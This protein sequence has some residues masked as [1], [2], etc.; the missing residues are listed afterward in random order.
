MW[1]SALLH[2]QRGLWLGLVTLFA[3]CA[4][5]TMPHA[6]A[7][8]S[9][10][11]PPKVAEASG[12]GEEALKGFRIPEGWK[13]ELYAAE[14]DVANPVALFIDNQ[15]QVYVCESFRQSRG[16][17]D[18]RSHDQAWT[19]ADIAARTVEDRIAY[20]RRLLPDAGASYE[21]EIDRIRRLVDRD[22]NGKADSSEV[23]VS[24]FH[25]I[26]EG[27]GAG[28]LVH[29]DSIFYTCIPKLWEFRDADRDG[30]V[31]SQRVI[32]D[33]F[34]VRVALRGH[35]MHGLVMGPDG[36]LYFSIGDRGYHVQTEGKLLADPASG[37]VFRC[38]LDGSHF[39]VF[40]TGLRNPQELAFDDYGR[41]FTGDN[42]SDSGDK[43]RWVYVVQ[44]GDTGWRMHYQYHPT[45]GPF[46][47]EH[48][49]EPFSAQTPAYIIPPVANV[50]DGPS[51]LTFYPGT[52]LSDRFLDTFLL[53]DFRGQAS[54]SGIRAL[55]VEEKGAFFTLSQ[56]EEL[57]WQVLA[58]DIDFGPDGSL[59]FSD[60]V[61]GWEGEGKGR[62]YRL[63]D[64]PN[65]KLGEITRRLLSSQLSKL[66]KANLVEL[67]HFPDRRVRYEAQWALAAQEEVDL[68]YQAA[69]AE[70]P[71][72]RHRLHGVW[73]LGQIARSSSPKAKP[74]ADRLMQLLDCPSDR[75]AALA[76]TMLAEA[77]HSAAEEKIVT[78]VQSP[79]VHVR[80]AAS[81][82]LGTLALPTG[83][84]AACQL[85]QTNQDADPIV[86]HAGIMALAGQ[87]NLDEV[88]GL[89]DHPIASVRR[90]AVVALRKRN[91]PRIA[92]F[93]DDIDSKVAAE[94]ARAIY[95]VLTLE[96][97]LPRLAA[98]LERAGAELEWS[99]RALHA[100]FRLG[101]K[102]NAEAVAQYVGGS[103]HSEE[104]RLEGLD[105]LKSWDAPGELDRL[106]SDYRPIANR[107]S[108]FAKEALRAQ[109]ALIAA[110]S[111]EV[112]TKGFEVAANLG[113]SE[114][115]PLLLSVLAD[116]NAPGHMRASAL[117][118]LSLIDPL[119]ATQQAEK[120]ATDRSS[121][122]KIAALQWL[123]NVAPEKTLEPIQQ[124]SQSTISM[125][126]QAAW[127]L[128]GALPEGLGLQWLRQGAKRYLEK[129]LPPDVRLNVFEA[130]QKR[131]P[132]QAGSE[133][134]AM[135]QNQNLAQ[136]ENR[137]GGYEDC[138]EGG[139][140]LVGKE[141][142]LQ[143]SQLSCVRC[144]RVGEKGGEVGPILSEIG[145][146]K[147][148]K[149]LLEAIVNPNAQI[150]EGFESTVVALEDG[151]V[152]TGLLKGETDTHLQLL[153]ADGSQVSIEKAAVAGRRKGLSSMPADLVKQL[154][155][156]ELRDL[157]AYLRALDGK[158]PAL[159]PKAAGH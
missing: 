16:V 159:L 95:D 14:P 30:K 47:R 87:R 141:I 116:G 113:I 155:P 100:H 17:T 80:V 130:V 50:G 117:T 86:R 140:M 24:G 7:W 84:Q 132:Q 143:R 81:M 152:V 91:D 66:D 133:W 59:Y 28:V 89:Q 51:G 38:E 88:V 82:A 93:L 96:K 20:F 111:N 15:N 5:P 101:G 158:N 35:D 138:I 156:R 21:T 56:N 29:G 92:D 142:F 128:I 40:A 2:R 8:Q 118:G 69:M 72:E 105:L 131:L 79:S 98:T 67:L 34:G 103:Q 134:E 44:G 106:T 49:W 3:S 112:R 110:S 1:C 75:V 90:A 123:A 150:A 63:F 83:V 137:V 71:Q 12:E 48:L 64:P 94:A 146:K 45:R 157:V 32:A 122:L 85:L 9:T 6:L 41:L 121:Q 13:C 33:G 145:I 114:V 104:L 125:E 10:P 53:C 37:A 77:G 54:N 135:L 149:Y 65:R 60:W 42:N 23:V 31:D 115:G 153:L 144:H 127:D 136:Q 139:R 148:G 126:R 119:V 99:R 73:G 19:V 154:T 43:A 78:L 61:N 11:N 102:Q 26:E 52:G 107:P 25:Q 4:S 129:D 108:P 27:T 39:E 124:L 76:V 109:L 55:K 151:E 36:R 46:N 147:D 62:I 70:Q 22:R 68:L 120:Y 57:V 74:A 97:E 58:T 18:N